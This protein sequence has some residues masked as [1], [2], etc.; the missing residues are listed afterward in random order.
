[1][2]SRET[3]N[4]HL[5][6]SN[7]KLALR[8]SLLLILLFICSQ[9]TAA[10]EYGSN[11][12]N[13]EIPDGTGEWEYS[14]IDISGAP[15]GAVVTGVDVYYRIVHN[16]A[17]DLKVDLEVQNSN[18]NYNLRNREG[19][20]EDNPSDTVTGI[21]AFN[22]LAVNRKWYLYASDWENIDAGEID[23]WW[24]K[25]YYDTPTTVEEIKQ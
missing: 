6:G 21:S 3:K 9:A 8:G 19:G 20:V 12:T 2:G 5:N 7:Y 24:I 14:I 11:G 10:Y 25:V 16:Y 23:S 22:G 4:V 1:M 15:A 13:V 17:G 18:K